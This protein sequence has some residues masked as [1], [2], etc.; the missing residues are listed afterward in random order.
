M[1]HRFRASLGWLR[2]V[3]F[4]IGCTGLAWLGPVRAL[5]HRPGCC[6]NVLWLRLRSERDGWRGNGYRERT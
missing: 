4:V 3:A 2:L 6:G 1:A 5:L